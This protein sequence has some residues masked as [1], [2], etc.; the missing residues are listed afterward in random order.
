[1]MNKLIIIMKNNKKL[2]KIIF[3][4]F[5]NYELKILIKLFYL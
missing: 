2:L 1:M 3:H 4:N 5:I